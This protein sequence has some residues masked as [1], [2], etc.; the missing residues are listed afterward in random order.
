MRL[1]EEDGAGILATTARVKQRRLGMDASVVGCRG[2]AK[3]GRVGGSSCANGTKG[4]DGDLGGRVE[5]REVAPKIGESIVEVG[6]RGEVR[7]A[8]VEKGFAEVLREAL[9]EEGARE[10]PVERVISGRG[11]NV[12]AHRGGLQLEGAEV[13]RVGMVDGARRMALELRESLLKPRDAGILRVGTAGEDELR[14]WSGGM[15]AGRGRWTYVAS[16]T[17][18]R[19]HSS[20][21]STQLV[22]VGKFLSQRTLR[23]RQREHDLSTSGPDG[24][25]DAVRLR[26]GGGGGGGGKAPEP[27]DSMRRRTTRRGNGS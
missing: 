21:R 3:Q 26:L 25:T 11:K 10:S 13:R 14:G 8:R 5:L 4:G 12:V 6:K 9:G 20:R 23:I 16:C 17:A 18:A 1:A 2:D 22:Q 7:A 15:S 24:F 19:S 27:D